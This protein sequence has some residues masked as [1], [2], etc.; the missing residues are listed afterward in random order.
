M[1]SDV[2]VYNA[3]APSQIVK[4]ISVKMHGTMDREAVEVF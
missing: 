3:L 2:K 4:L 1:I